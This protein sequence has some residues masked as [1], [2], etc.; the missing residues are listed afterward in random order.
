M[1]LSVTD[2]MGRPGGTRDL[3]TVLARESLDV[4]L[5]QWGPADEALSGPLEVVLR[6]EMLVE[7]LL[8]RGTVSFRTSVP[9]ARCLTEV[10]TDN[11]V[12]VAELFIDPDRL[13]DDDELEA[14]YELLPEGVI[15]IEALLR[16]AILSA[17]PVRA[18]CRGDCRGLCATCGADLNASECG[19]GLAVS[20]DPRWSVLQALRLP[21]A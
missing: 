17:L 18:L 1:R 11:A 21:P 9:C 13:L 19:H 16:D 15:D 12:T 4:P 7:G 14:G 20:P 5:G 10:V 3:S 8:A 6:L 2:L